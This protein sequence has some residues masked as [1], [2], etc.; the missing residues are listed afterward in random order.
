MLLSPVGLPPKTPLICKL[1][2]TPHFP[3]CDNPDLVTPLDNLHLVFSSESR[4]SAR[5]VMNSGV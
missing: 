3:S 2:D 5:A 4:P 1:A